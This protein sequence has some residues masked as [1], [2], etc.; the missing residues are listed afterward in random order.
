MK[1]KLMK[2][3]M[4]MILRLMKEKLLIQKNYHNKM[5]FF[6]INELKL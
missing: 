2:K 5:Y 1:M 6:I 4:K 3:S